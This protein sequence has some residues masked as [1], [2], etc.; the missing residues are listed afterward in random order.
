MPD[1]KVI[2]ERAEVFAFQNKDAFDLVVAR[3]VAK[4]NIL[5]ELCLP[6][7][8]QEGYFIAMKSH[9]QTELKEA[10]KAFIKLGGKVVSLKTFTLP[11]EESLRT[12]VKIQKTKP[13]PLNYPRQFK[14]IKANPL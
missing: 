7:V 10:Q 3:A 12:L 9:L 4:L 6:L 8:K 14:Q 1:I 13:T 2:N 5:A 11:I